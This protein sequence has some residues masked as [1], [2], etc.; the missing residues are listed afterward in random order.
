MQSSLRGY[1]FAVLQNAEADP[2]SGGARSVADDLRQVTD[3]TGS[4]PDLSRALTDEMVPPAARRAVVQQLFSDRIVAPALRIVTWATIAEH[5]DELLSVLNDATE[6]AL[7]FVN[8]GMQEF[9]QQEPLYGRLGARRHAAGYA[10]AVFEDI[11]ETSEL[12]TIEEQL[13]SLARVLSDSTPLRSAL[14]DSSR[15]VG[16][17]RNLI[18][19]LLDGKVSAVTIRLARAS[20]GVRSRD[21]G[22][23]VAWMAEL[24]AEARGWRV[25]NVTSARDLDEQERNDLAQAL[26]EVAGNPVE[27]LVTQNPELLGGAV[28]SIGNVLVDATAQHKLDLISEQFLGSLAA[29]G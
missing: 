10:A 13:F 2:A 19:S 12:E 24:T 27:L 3:V 18:S 17:R 7:E 22:G 14:S 4:T 6:L 20:L 26:Q 16:D 8:L 23:S 29:Q 11:A 15:P 25:A 5:A 9:E 1:E 28:V 21:P